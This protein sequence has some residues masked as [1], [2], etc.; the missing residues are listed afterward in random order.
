MAGAAIPC[1]RN[2][3]T[4]SPPQQQREIY[5]LP[6]DSTTPPPE[7]IPTF[8]TLICNKKYDPKPTIELFNLIMNLSPNSS[9]TKI[10]NIQSLI[11]QKAD[12][13]ASGKNDNDSWSLLD[14]ASNK[15]LTD[16]FKSLIL[17][18]AYLTHHKF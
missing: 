3:P 6:T 18:G 13:N 15:M 17:S 10:K 7:K 12:P 2:T 14:I 4:P 8:T 5:T 16:V 1:R 11:S 9:D